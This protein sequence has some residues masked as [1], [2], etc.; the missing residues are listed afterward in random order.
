MNFD[1]VAPL[2]RWLEYGTFGPALQ[3]RRMQY[4]N[5]IADARKVL[6]LGDG[7]G[8]F[9]AEFLKRDRGAMVDSIDASEVMTRLAKRRIIRSRAG[10]ERIRF[11]VGNAMRL[12]LPGGYDLVVTHFFLDCFR[13]DEVEKLA[14]RIAAATSPGARWVISEFRIP[15]TGIRRWAAKLLIKILYLGFRILA[16]LKINELP[17][18]GRALEAAGFQKVRQKR[19][20]GGLLVSQLWQRGRTKG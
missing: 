14:G 5:E 11:A 17:D 7:D 19:A 12:E 6:I 16:G 18:Y 20:L 1:F 3:R 9:T 13:T 2:Y 15:R 4:L 10:L 8:R